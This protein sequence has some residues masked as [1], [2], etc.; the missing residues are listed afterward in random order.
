MKKLNI[1]KEHFEKS[2]YY[3]NK[4]GRLAFVSESGELFKTETG[5]ILKFKE[6]VNPKNAIKDELRDAEM[7]DDIDADIDGDDYENTSPEKKKKLNNSKPKRFNNFND[8]KKYIERQA[9]NKE[10][11]A[12]IDGDGRLGSVADEGNIILWLNEI[13]DDTNVEIIKPPARYWYD[14]ELKVGSKS[15]YTNIKTTAGGADNISSKEGVLY[16]LS[17]GK[18]SDYKTFIKNRGQF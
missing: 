3:Q 5:N 13:F 15:Y 8:L 4:Y 12:A 1:T 17:G 14:I 9:Y 16:Y 7:G 18:T 6:R 11:G 2:N 10:V